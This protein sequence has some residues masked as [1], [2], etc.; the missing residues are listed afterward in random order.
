MG[1][2]GS[3]SASLPTDESIVYEVSKESREEVEIIP[4]MPMESMYKAAQHI[5]MTYIANEAPH[6]I[7]CSRR[8]RE[9]L[10]RDLTSDN[11]NNGGHN[12]HRTMFDSLQQKTFDIMLNDSFPK[13]LEA[14][15]YN[16]LRETPGRP[17]YLPP[18]VEVYSM[19]PEGRI[20]LFTQVLNTAALLNDLSVFF[21][22]IYCEESLLFYLAVQKFSQSFAN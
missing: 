7:D 12:I 13:L 5:F 21:K 11:N 17:V 18:K 3:T 1:L 4:N 2:C 14:D 16:R 20:R 15:A 10:R 22:R 9:A 19:K 6:L 8:E